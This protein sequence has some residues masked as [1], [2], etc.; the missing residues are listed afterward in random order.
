MSRFSP[1]TSVDELLWEVVP[2]WPIRG[3][4]P[5][6]AAVLWVLHPSSGGTRGCVLPG[7]SR[8]AI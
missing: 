7:V 4:A 2:V 8:A 6:G 5:R 1:P 3:S